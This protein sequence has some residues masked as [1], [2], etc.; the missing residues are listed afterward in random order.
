[1]RPAHTLKS[2]SRTVG[3]SRLGVLYHDHGIGTGG[4]R[5]ARHDFHC[6]P[7]RELLIK[8]FSGS[9]LAGPQELNR[10][11]SQ[12]LRANPEAVARGAMER[13]VIAVGNDILGRMFELAG[14]KDAPLVVIPTANGADDFPADWP[15][16]KMFK[17]FGATS[18]S[19]LHTKDRAVAD[20][21]AFVRRIATAKIVWFVGGRQWRLAGGRDLALMFSLGTGHAPRA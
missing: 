17:N 21:D 10:N 9:N 16:L 20:S 15:G 14:G 2:A 3:A 18:I 11:G 19:L 1:M 12:I 7:G 5:R 13:R 8:T 6:L 4:Q